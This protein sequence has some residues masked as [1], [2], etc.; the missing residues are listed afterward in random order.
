MTAIP[1]I[2]TASGQTEWWTPAWLWQAVKQ[3]MGG[4]DLDPCSNSRENP[5]VPATTLYTREDDGLARAWFGRVYLNPP[6]GRGIEKWVCKMVHSYEIGSVTQAVLAVPAS[7]ETRWFAPLWNYLICF[8]QGRCFFIDGKTGAVPENGG[9][10]PVAY[11]YLGLE[12]AR[13]ASVFSQFGSVVSGEQILA[14]RRDVAV[15]AA[16]TP[17]LLAPGRPTGDNRYGITVS[18]RGTDARY[19]AAKLRRDAPAIFERLK[20][21]EFASIAAAERA[22]GLFREDRRVTL[23]AGP[24]RAA[25]TLRAKFDPEFLRQLAAELL[26]EPG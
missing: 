9:P 7:T 18:R 10:T 14:G 12:F 25:E 8:A 20:Q 23:P 13:F 16:R 4:I 6:W 21:G 5:S 24:E 17:E 3:V 11:V 15:V 19:R 1:G 2:T 22:A 26:R